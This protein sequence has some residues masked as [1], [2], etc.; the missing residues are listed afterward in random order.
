MREKDEHTRYGHGTEGEQTDCL[1][2]D[3]ADQQGGKRACQQIPEGVQG[4]Q[5]A[6]LHLIKPQ[7]AL[8]ARDGWTFDIFRKAEDQKADEYGQ[9]LQRIIAFG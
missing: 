3:F 1:D 8:D 5:G 2:A 4:Q 9:Q 7:I 6:Q